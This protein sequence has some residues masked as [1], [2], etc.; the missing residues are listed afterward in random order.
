MLA[1]P[2]LSAAD[3]AEIPKL[4]GKW[5]EL[6]ELEMESKPSSFLE[7]LQEINL[8]CAGFSSLKMTGS[9][10]KE[11]VA[12]IVRYLPEIRHICLD[13][14][15]FPREHL[16][17]LIGGCRELETL[18]VHDCVGFEADEEVVERASGIRSFRYE[19]CTLCMEFDSDLDCECDPFHVHVI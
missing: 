13:K 14:S 17:E 1:L 18:S 10:K 15:Y 7:M 16:V 9:I 2:S 12:A 11:D 19:G 8:N 5:K 4:V 3:E 6:E